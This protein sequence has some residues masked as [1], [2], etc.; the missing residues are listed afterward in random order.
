MW[1]EDNRT[2]VETAL[3]NI[4]SAGFTSNGWVCLVMSNGYNVLIPR[5]DLAKINAMVD[6]LD[7]VTA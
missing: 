1:I 4:M 3:G 5:S 6:E 7:T 2:K